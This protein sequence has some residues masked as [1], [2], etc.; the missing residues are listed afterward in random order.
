M[1]AALGGKTIYVTK[2]AR[3]DE[4]ACID[5]NK[6]RN[7][8]IVYPMYILVFGKKNKEGLPRVLVPPRAVQYRPQAAPRRRS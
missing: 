2:I 1:S 8:C 6:D 5:V 4:S 7:V 3:A